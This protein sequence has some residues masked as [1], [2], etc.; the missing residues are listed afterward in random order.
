MN[1]ADTFKAGLKTFRT[2][3]DL[4]NEP[5][6]IIARVKLTK[7]LKPLVLL[8]T[9]RDQLRK[10]IFLLLK[11]YIKLFLIG[12]YTEYGERKV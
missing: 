11:S 10:T 9:G 7:S 12:N 6:D 3:N 5:C 8:M 1:V 2:L 4:W